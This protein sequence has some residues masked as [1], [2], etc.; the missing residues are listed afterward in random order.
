MEGCAGRAHFRERTGL[1]IPVAIVVSLRPHIL[2]ILRARLFHHLRLLVVALAAVCGGMLNHR[3]VA[4]VRVV[5]DA[6]PTAPAPG[7]PVVTGSHRVVVRERVS[8]ESIHADAVTVAGPAAA[9]L[10]NE[11]PARDPLSA[12]L[13]TLLG[14]AFGL[15]GL[16]LPVPRAPRRAAPAFARLLGASVAPQAP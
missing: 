12:W 3:H 1:P 14:L 6:A 4:V 7:A 2:T 16:A 5:A 10:P 11:D 8:L 15:A 13:T 9:W